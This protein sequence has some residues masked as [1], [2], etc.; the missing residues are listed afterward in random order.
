[1]ILEKG[2]SYI[3][4][5]EKGSPK[6]LRKDISKTQH[7]EKGHACVHSMLILQ[8]KMLLQQGPCRSGS[9][10]NGFCIDFFDLFIVFFW[11]FFGD[12]ILIFEWKLWLPQIDFFWRNQFRNIDFL[13]KSKLSKVY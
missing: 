7:L 12:L 6:N 9:W 8:E 10:G 2:H 4:N 3:Q 11:L 1:L 13:Y 5:L